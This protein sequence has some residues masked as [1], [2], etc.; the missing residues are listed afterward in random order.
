MPH[1]EEQGAWN[2]WRE[3]P[4]CAEGADQTPTPPVARVDGLSPLRVEQLC[5]AEDSPHCVPLGPQSLPLWGKG[6]QKGKKI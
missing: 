4:V 5:K 6:S 1:P 3:G 2:P